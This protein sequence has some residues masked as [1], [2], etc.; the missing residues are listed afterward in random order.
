MSR[1]A[2]I[3]ERS[4]IDNTTFY[5]KCS[6]DEEYTAETFPWKRQTRNFSRDESLNQKASAKARKSMKFGM[7]DD[8]FSEYHYS[9][10]FKNEGIPNSTY[11][12]ISMATIGLKFSVVGLHYHVSL[13]CSS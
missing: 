8:S 11:K 1:S 6:D 9:P 4:F 5:L 12:V 3:R 2:T 7:I 10:K 13:A